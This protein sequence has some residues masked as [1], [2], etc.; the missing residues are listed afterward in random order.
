MLF[1]FLTVAGQK[2]NHLRIGGPFDQSRECELAVSSSWK[3]KNFMLR[4]N[5]VEQST[6]PEVT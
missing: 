2:P 3:E 5:G 6:S 1:A 4:S